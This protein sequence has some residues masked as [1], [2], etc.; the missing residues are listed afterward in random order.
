MKNLK[1]RLAQ[2]EAENE[3]TDNGPDWSSFMSACQ[4]GT[5]PEFVEENPTLLSFFEEAAK[6]EPDKL[7]TRIA[8]LPEAINL[9][10]PEEQL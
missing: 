8:E 4:R 6:D 2:L 3:T 1:A 10:P 9:L 5:L 7:E